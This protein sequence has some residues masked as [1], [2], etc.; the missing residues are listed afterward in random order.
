MKYPD[1][2][3]LLWVECWTMAGLS[4]YTDEWRFLVG[5]LVPFAV[6]LMYMWKGDK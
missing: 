5:G 3:A 4:A 1:R 6:W 2:L